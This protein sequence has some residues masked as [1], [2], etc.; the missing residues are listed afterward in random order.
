[1]ITKHLKGLLMVFAWKRLNAFQGQNHNF[2][3]FWFDSIKSKNKRFVIHWRKFYNFWMCILKDIHVCKIKSTPWVDSWHKGLNGTQN[4]FGW[5]S[6]WVDPMDRPYES[7]SAALQ[8]KITEQSFSAVFHRGRPHESTHEH[9]S[10][11]WVDPCDEKFLQRLVFN[12]FRL[13]LMLI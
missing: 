10:T 13:H 11:L 6:L 9:E 1:M 12:L 2:T 7:T 8:A 5:H 3:K 4:F